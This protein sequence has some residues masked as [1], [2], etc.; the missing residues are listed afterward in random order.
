MTR[1]TFAEIEAQITDAE[2]RGDTAWRELAGLVTVVHRQELWKQ[3]TVPVGIETEERRP[4]KTFVEW[5]EVCR[6]RSKS[7]GYN[8]LKAHAYSTVV[9]CERQARELIGL[10]EEDARRL[11]DKATEGGTRETTAEEL[12]RMRAE[13]AIKDRQESKSKAKRRVKQIEEAATAKKLA[14][15]ME[16]A[17]GLAGQH[18]GTPEECFTDL[19]KWRD[20]WRGQVELEK[21]A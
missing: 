11:V 1:I 13:D 6:E 17:I 8:L 14:K 16:K 20:Y 19:E 10:S 3:A 15:A 12:A 9:D 18:S 4:C 7:W 5:L 21:A 2:E